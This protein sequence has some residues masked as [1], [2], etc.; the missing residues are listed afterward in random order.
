[1]SKAAQAFITL[2]TARRAAEA[3]PAPVAPEAR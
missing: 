3:A 1:L 2:V